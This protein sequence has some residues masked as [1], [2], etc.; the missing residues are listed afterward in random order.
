M[1][2]FVYV[3]WACVRGLFDSLSVPSFCLMFPSPFPSRRVKQLALHPVFLRCELISSRFQMEQYN[4]MH[5]PQF[6]GASRASRAGV[7]PVRQ[8]ERL[9][10]N[11]VLL[12]FSQDD[13]LHCITTLVSSLELSNQLLQCVVRQLF[14]MNFLNHFVYV[15]LIISTFHLVSLINLLLYTARLY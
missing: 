3:C 7:Q 13:R 14:I 15:H 9:R 4:S 2:F 6:Q 10:F 12:T 5:Y 11:N 8:T 1:P